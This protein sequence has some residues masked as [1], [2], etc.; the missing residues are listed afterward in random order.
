MT[1]AILTTLAAILPGGDTFPNTTL[2]AP[3][4]QFVSASPGW[5]PL[6]WPVPKKHKRRKHHPKPK[7]APPMSSALASWYGDHGTGACGV[8]DVQSGYRFAS[9]FLRCGTRVRFCYHGQCVEGVMSDHGP[10]VSGRTFDLNANLKSALGCSDL[11]T[12]LY[13]VE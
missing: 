7:P 13:R 12:L 9:L 3:S 10:Y 6:N 4:P 2:Q 11:C 5:G 1:I 8:G